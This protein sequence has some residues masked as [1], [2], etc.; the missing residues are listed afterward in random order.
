M[1]LPTLTG[2]NS[3]V[4]D[5]RSKV[6]VSFERVFRGALMYGLGLGLGLGLRRY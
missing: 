6:M 2:Y 5:P 3:G 1:C 4:G